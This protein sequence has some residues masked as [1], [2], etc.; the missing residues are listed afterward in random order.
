[1]SEGFAIDPLLTYLPSTINSLDSVNIVHTPT[2]PDPVPEPTF[3]LLLTLIHPSKRVCTSNRKTKSTKPEAENKGPYDIPVQIEWDAFLDIIAE[4]L[5]L[6]HFD[7]VVP[8]LEWHWL[9][10]AS[11]PWLP[12]QDKAGLTSMLKKVRSK[13]EPY[14]I[15]RMQVPQKKA[16]P[17]DIF[18]DPG[19]DLEDNP[20]A[21]KVRIQAIAV[22]YTV[23]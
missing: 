1:M 20:V 3:E 6:R 14:V 18:E 8:S 16:N 5:S 15:V 13:S 12:V 4:K 10:P 11:S 22:A 17:L 7:L 23:V 2:P 19:T 9:K 21:K